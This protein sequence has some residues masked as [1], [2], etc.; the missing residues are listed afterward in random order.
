MK[1]G[2]R[3]NSNT[4]EFVTIMTTGDAVDFGDM[5]TAR[6]QHMACSNSTRGIISGGKVSSMTNIIEFIT[7]ATLGNGIDFGD[8]T[9]TNNRDGASGSSKTRGI[10]GAGGDPGASPYAKTDTINSVEIAT[11]GDAVDFGNL[12]QTRNHMAGCSNGHGGL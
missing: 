4:I 12:T 1:V 11:T 3:K 5:T 9:Y 10:V 6:E 7:I 2:S 8:M